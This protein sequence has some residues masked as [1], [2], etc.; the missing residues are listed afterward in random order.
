ME[1]NYHK[2]CYQDLNIPTEWW[3]I[4]YSN[5]ECASFVFN[6]Y[7]IFIA[8]KDDPDNVIIGLKAKYAG[9]RFYI[10]AYD[11]SGIDDYTDY[12]LSDDFDD[13]LKYT[14]TPNKLKPLA[15]L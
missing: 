2:E 14:A 8:A 6:G 5:D 11:E 12:Y 3:N 7:H 13:V 15:F 4:S 1:N 9:D 10:K